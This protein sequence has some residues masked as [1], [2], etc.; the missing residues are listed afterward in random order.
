MFFKSLLFSFLLFQYSE[1]LFSQPFRKVAFKLNPYSKQ[2]T[3]NTKRKIIV[4][5][6]GTICT[7]TKSDYE[8]AKPIFENIDIFNNLYE[9]GNEI[10]YW[11]SR[12]SISGKKWDKL[13]FKQLKEWNVRYN[14][15]NMGKPHYDVWIDD[16]AY[17]AIS[18]C[19]DL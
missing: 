11:T 19:K 7:L 12:G 8:N 10:H 2:K 1:S 13:T 16:K 14:S 4:D 5:I 17:N 18:F 15:L 3:F 6:D 9:K